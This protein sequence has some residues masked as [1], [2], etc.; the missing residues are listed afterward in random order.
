MAPREARWCPVARRRPSRPT[1][2]LLLLLL[3]LTAACC[4]AAAADARPLLPTA[5]GARRG[6][7]DNGLGLTPQMGWNSWNH[8]QCDIN[9]TVIR[10]TA[11]ALVATGLAKAGYTYVN[12]DDCWADDQRTKEGYMTANPKTFPSGIKA[13]ADYVHSK[14]LKLGLYS[15]A[16]TRTCSDRMPGSLGHEDTDA[17]TFASWDVDYLKYDNCY[18]DGTPETERFPRMSRALKDSG[19]PIF[20]SLCEW[21]Y[22]EVAKWGATSGN[23]WRTTGDINDTW[24]G[25]LDNI[26]RN[27]AFAQY[28]KPRGWNDPDMLEVGNGGMTYDEYV[29][30]FSL[31]AVAKAP[32]IIGCDVT[33]ISK[34][35]L[36]ILSNA[37]VIAINQDRLGIQGK[38]VRDYGNDLEVWT[39]RLSRH[40]QAVLLLN[41]GAA[42]SASITA[43]WPDVGI[44]PG[45]AVEARDVWKHETL[46]GKFAGSLTAAVEPHSCKLFVLTPVPR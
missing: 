19:R 46:P 24:T 7:L 30:H 2:V 29:V 10:S 33:S 6:L 21:G 18:R 35:T 17:K 40:R 34:E 3:L 38:K 23:S 36:G 8:F 27:D 28:A 44:R 37:E 1:A 45:V 43:A 5:S 31:W 12:L 16:G 20:F 25:M 9:E 42:R 11:D 15:S 32:L 14:G 13:L 41:R 4:L 26:D 22:M 39:G